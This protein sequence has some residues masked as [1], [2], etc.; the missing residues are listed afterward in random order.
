MHL[1]A[2]APRRRRPVSYTL[3]STRS[4]PAAMPAFQTANTSDS[5]AAPLKK[6]KH[7]VVQHSDAQG[8]GGHCS[9]SRGPLLLR[10]AWVEKVVAARSA[11]SQSMALAKSVAGGS[12]RQHGRTQSHSF[13]LGVKTSQSAA[14][15]TFTSFA[16]RRALPNSSVNRTR[17]GKAP[18]P[19][20]S[21][22]SSSASR[23]GPLASAGRLPLR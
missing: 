7:A 12:P 5:E 19:R 2:R 20:C 22:G 11:Q 6:G 4:E 3:G 8:Y 9:A 15:R 10:K 1:A 16:S 21:Q 13:T 18:W 14:S 23:P 17:Y